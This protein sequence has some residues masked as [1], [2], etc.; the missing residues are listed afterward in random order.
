MRRWRC[1][2]RAFRPTH[3]S[4]LDLS[5][6]AENLCLDI[7]NLCFHIA[8]LGLHIVNLGLHVVNLGLHV[9][10]GEIISPSRGP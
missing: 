1:S 10:L 8:N 6:E 3:Q 4:R 5:C 9:V 7:V 2:S